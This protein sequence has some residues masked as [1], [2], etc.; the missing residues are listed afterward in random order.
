M[1]L[2]LTKNIQA[3]YSESPS[4]FITTIDPKNRGRFEQILSEK[5]CDY[6]CI[7]TVTKEP[8]LKIKGID[9]KEIINRDINILGAK[10]KST[11]GGLI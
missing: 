4:R 3:L 1:T 7:G 9:G 10:Y 11:Y 8:I 5:G 2:K 6:S